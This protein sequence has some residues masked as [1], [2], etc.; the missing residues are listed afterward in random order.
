MFES[1]C[2]CMPITHFGGQYPDIALL[3]SLKSSY[4]TD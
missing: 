4:I 3:V 1:D 2:N